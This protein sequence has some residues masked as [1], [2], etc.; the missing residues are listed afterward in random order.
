MVIC[1]FPS[2]PCVNRKN[3]NIGQSRKWT[4]VMPWLIMLT[5]DVTDTVLFCGCLGCSRVDGRLT[6][7][8]VRSF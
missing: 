3:M 1:M 6:S 4:A 7:G 2:Q 5:D 8:D